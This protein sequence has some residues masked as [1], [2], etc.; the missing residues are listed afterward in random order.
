MTPKIK[1][2]GQGQLDVIVDGDVV[3]SRQQAGRFPTAGEIVEACAPLK[4]GKVAKPVKMAAG[5]AISKLDEY[6]D[7]DEVEFIKQKTD[8]KEQ[9]LSEKKQEKF[10]SWFEKLKKKSDFVSYTAE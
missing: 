5:W 10:N 1:M 6:Q 2:G 9:L 3:F 8:F 7:I 4:I